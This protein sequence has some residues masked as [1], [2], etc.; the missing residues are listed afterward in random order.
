MIAFKK[1]LFVSENLKVKWLK[2][3][4]RI[5]QT[6]KHKNLQRSKGSLSLTEV[7]MTSKLT[8]FCG[9]FTFARD[10]FSVRGSI[11][12]TLNTHVKFEKPLHSEKILVWC[13]F[14][15]NLIIE[16]FFIEDTLNVDWYLSKLKGQVIPILRRKRKLS[17][18]SFQLDGHYPT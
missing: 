3:I 18:V 5:L 7:W 13:G 10:N 12:A 6:K 11:L 14:T 4:F 16:L 1:F 17:S 15:S 9:L 8:Q 2:M